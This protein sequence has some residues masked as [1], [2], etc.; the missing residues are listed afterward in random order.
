MPVFF[1]ADKLNDDRKIWVITEAKDD[2]G[3]RLATT[4]LIPDEY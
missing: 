2:D 4:V 3:R 1:S